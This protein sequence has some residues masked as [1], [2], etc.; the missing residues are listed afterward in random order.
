METGADII[1]RH[2]LYF[3]GGDPDNG[4]LYLCAPL[5]SAEAAVTAAIEQLRAAGLWSA[6]ERKQVPESHKAAYAEQMQFIDSFEFVSAGKTLLAARYDHPKYPSSALR[7]DEWRNA[8]GG[9]DK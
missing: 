6:D 9:A 7:W 8:L 2:D 1:Q 3:D 4:S 5:D